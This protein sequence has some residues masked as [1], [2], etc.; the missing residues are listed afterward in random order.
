MRKEVLQGK[1]YGGSKRYHFET[2]SAKK[3]EELIWYSFDDCI[4]RHSRLGVSWKIKRNRKCERRVHVFSTCGRKF[5]RIE[6]GAVI[7]ST[8]VY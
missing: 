2:A 3:Q 6:K 7:T 8:G 5:V 4:L 1:T